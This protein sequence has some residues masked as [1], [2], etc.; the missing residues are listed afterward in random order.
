[1]D[2]NSK[3]YE[4]DKSKMIFKL[5]M[6]QTLNICKETSVKKFNAM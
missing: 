3:R 1:M 6:Q 5:L 4:K 2:N